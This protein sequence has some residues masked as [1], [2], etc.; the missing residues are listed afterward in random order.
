MKELHHHKGMGNWTPL[1]KILEEYLVSK[2]VDI[3]QFKEKF[4]EFRCYFNATNE[5]AYEI[6][7]AINLASFLCSKMDDTTCLYE[8]ELRGV[9][10]FAK[11]LSAKLEAENKPTGWISSVYFCGF[12][13]KS[14]E[15][16]IMQDYDEAVLLSDK[17]IGKYGR[18][19]FKPFLTVKWTKL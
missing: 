18:W 15:K 19:F 5:N 10:D 3:I 1:L 7:G 12:E 4:F 6:E 14:I 17:V 9:L 16:F 11:F 13:L 8:D 2:D